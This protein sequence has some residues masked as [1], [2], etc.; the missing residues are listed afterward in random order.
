MSETALFK[1]YFNKL[2]DEYDQDYYLT[3]KALHQLNLSYSTFPS[4]LRQFNEQSR[5]K[6][7]RSIQKLHQVIEYGPSM[8]HEIVQYYVILFTENSEERGPSTEVNSQ[9]SDAKAPKKGYLLGKEKVGSFSIL[10]FWP[11]TRQSEIETHP[12]LISKELDDLI[13]HP[14]HYSDV[15]LITE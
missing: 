1:V 5:K 13:A 7:T 12:A 9:T 15:I 10:G 6:Q 3:F 8:S 14:M 11:Y 4:F 2:T